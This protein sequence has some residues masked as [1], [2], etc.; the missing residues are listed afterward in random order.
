[1]QVGQNMNMV[2]HPV[3]PVQNAFS[4][5][6]YSPDVLVECFMLFCWN[7]AFPVVSAKYDVIEDL[8]IAV[9]GIFCI[10]ETLTGFR[11]IITVFIPQFHWGLFTDNSY[12]VIM[13]KP[14][15]SLEFVG[16][17]DGCLQKTLTELFLV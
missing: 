16:I 9:H 7:R 17:I 8:P 1:M 13:C 10:W 4:F 3:Y 2:F 11:I 14:A 5:R 12:R 6:N 15:I